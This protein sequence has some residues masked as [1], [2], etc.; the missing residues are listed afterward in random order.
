MQPIVRAFEERDQDAVTALSLRAWAPVFASLQEVLGESG[1]YSQMH[2]DWRVDQ[3][4]AVRAA[5]GAEG[6]R[7]WVAETDTVVGF[8][9]ARLDHRE[10]MGEIYMIAVDPDHQRKGIGSLLTSCALEWFRDSGMTL[11]MVETGGDPGHAPAR[12]TY[13]QAG[14]VHLPIARYFKKL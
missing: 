7:V 9:A 10:S 6:M 11:A 4:E 14:F 5:C 13:E 3:K 2:S 1:V 12:R 8:V